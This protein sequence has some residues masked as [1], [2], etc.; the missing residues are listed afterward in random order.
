MSGDGSSSNCI[1]FY[2][3]KIHGFSVVYL[4]QLGGTHGNEIIGTYNY[5]GSSGW[6]GSDMDV[7][8]VMGNAGGRR[9]GAN[10]IDDGSGDM[11]LRREK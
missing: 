3:G 8:N 10:L 6:T 2:I 9:S 5:L 7:E 11:R 1:L 4:R